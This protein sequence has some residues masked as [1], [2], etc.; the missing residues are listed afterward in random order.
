MRIGF[1]FG[2]LCDFCLECLYRMYY[3]SDDCGGDFDM[4]TAVDADLD[5]DCSDM[6]CY[7]Y[8]NSGTSYSM[9]GFCD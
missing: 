9:E 1:V 3:G 7:S 8:D 2:M 4:W 6:D 5:D